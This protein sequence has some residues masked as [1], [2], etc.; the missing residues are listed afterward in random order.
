MTHA[1]AIVFDAPNTVGTVV[2]VA[3]GDPQ[4]LQMMIDWQ[5]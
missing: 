1:S 4:C 5:A 2:R 3:F